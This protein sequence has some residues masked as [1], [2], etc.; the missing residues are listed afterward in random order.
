MPGRSGFGN[1][2]SGVGPL[3]RAPA[4]TY[5]R[6]G[7]GSS[8]VISGN[9]GN[10]VVNT[11]MRGRAGNT[12]GG[13]FIGTDANGTMAVP[14]VANGEF[15]GNGATDNMIGGTA[16]GARDLISGNTTGWRRVN[17][18]DQRQ[19]GRG[20][21]H[22]PAETGTAALANG[23][24]GVA[25]LDGASGNTIGGH[26]RPA[27]AMS[28]R[29]TRPTA[30]TSPTPARTATSSRATTSAPTRPA[31]HA[32]PN[33][34]RRVHRTPAAASNTIGGTTAAAR[35]VIS[36]NALGRRPHRRRGT[37]GNVV[38]GNYIGT[39]ASGYAGPGQRR[40]GVDI[41]SG[42]SGNTIGGTAAADRNVISG[43]GGDGV[44]ISD[45]G[46]A[47]NVVEGD[48][49]GTDATG[50]LALPNDDGVV[51][52]NGATDNTIGGT[53]AGARNVISGNIRDGV[54]IV[55]SGPRA[56][57][58]RAT[59]SATTAGG[60][61]ALGND[62][63]GVAIY[64]GASSNTIGGTAAG[65]G[66]IISGNVSDGVDIS[67]PGTTGNVVEGDF[68]GT[69]VDRHAALPNRPSAS[70][71]NG[72]TDNTIGGTTAAARDVISGNSWDGVHIV[73]SGAT[74]NVVEGDYIGTNAS[75]TAALGNG[76]SGVAIY[77]GA[78]GNMIG[79]R[80]P[81]PAT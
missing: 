31:L 32:L 62:A 40:H 72:A 6:G 39:D 57:W 69:D 42:A 21:L 27:P 67:D 4:T 81:A 53:T 63:S 8:D 14:N 51:I 30:C 74:G 78:S 10:G 18:R 35:N 60:A 16:V 76:A 56:T 44:Y 7:A 75:G 28:S 68:I 36:G 43:N 3:R 1:T 48:Y 50:T 12:V 19:S 29:A 79:G 77:A 22:R 26:D 58:S 45:S 20:Q 25:I 55:G 54:D 5:R 73:G 33:D 23:A 80:R 37:T 17:G 46:T 47:S 66:N 15:I 59:T 65:A 49:I 61:A 71:S 2:Q 34:A 13:K 11:P 41:F 70:S 64:A 9:R 52:Q 24:S 38:E